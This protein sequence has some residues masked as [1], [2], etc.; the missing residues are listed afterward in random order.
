MYSLADIFAAANKEALPTATVKH[1]FEVIGN[2]AG[3]I[4]TITRLH[5]R[6]DSDAEAW[7]RRMLIIDF[8]QPTAASRT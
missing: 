7:R 2:F 6:L 4:T 3:I 8:N 5:V 1:R